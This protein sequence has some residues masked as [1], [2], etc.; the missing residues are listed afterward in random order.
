[1]LYIIIGYATV[2]VIGMLI[3]RFGFTHRGRVGKHACGR[4][5]T[6][7]MRPAYGV[8][9]QWAVD[10]N[11]MRR[12]LIADPRCTLTYPAATGDI[13]KGLLCSEEPELFAGYQESVSSHG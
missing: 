1:M 12:D 11:A 13:H 3:G 5:N 2:M 9:A 6:T 8:D 10:L 4:L 7:A